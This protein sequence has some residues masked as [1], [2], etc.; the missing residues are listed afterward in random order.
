MHRFEIFG[1]ELPQIEIVQ[2]FNGQHVHELE[3]LFNERKP[4]YLHSAHFKVETENRSLRDITDYI[5]FQ[6]GRLK[7]E[8]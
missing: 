4:H 1:D 7:G 2:L 6:I 5:A 3:K 8:I